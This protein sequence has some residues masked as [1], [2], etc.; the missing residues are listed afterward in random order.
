MKYIVGLSS[1][2]LIGF[3]IYKNLEQKQQRKIREELVM[4]KEEMIE[5]I[6]SMCPET[7]ENSPSPPNQLLSTS[8][9]NS[10]TMVH[11]EN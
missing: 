11:T 7:P 10:F 5:L 2:G 4:K 9:T 1:L 8:P 3:I 6:F